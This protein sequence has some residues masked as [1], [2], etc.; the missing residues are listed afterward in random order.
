MTDVLPLY[1]IELERAT[2]GR[3]ALAAF[4]ECRQKAEPFS[5]EGWIAY[6]KAA[7]DAYT[8]VA[9]AQSFDELMRCHLTEG[10]ALLSHV[11]TDL[12]HFLDGLVNRRDF[13]NGVFAIIA[14]KV[15]WNRDDNQLNGEPEFP[16]AVA[17][18]AALS[19][20]AESLDP[21]L[22]IHYLIHDASARFEEEAEEARWRRASEARRALYRR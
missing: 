8:N 6:S 11:V 1:P 20:R 3:I 17:L 10:I 19:L 16:D 13:A 15:T 22:G 9:D 4:S 12:L 7:V 21:D 2:R 14:E 5:F 18:G